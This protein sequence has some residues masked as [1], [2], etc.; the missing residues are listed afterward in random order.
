VPLGFVMS[1]IWN[2]IRVYSSQASWQLWSKGAMS[3]AP[4]LRCGQ[5]ACY[6]KAAQSLDQFRTK[7]DG[8]RNQTCLTCCVCRAC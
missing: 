6:T 2:T 4:T 3:A 1:H 7:K 5:V 8:G